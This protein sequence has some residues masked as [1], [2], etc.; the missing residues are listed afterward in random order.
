MLHTIIGCQYETNVTIKCQC[1]ANIGIISLDKISPLGLLILPRVICSLTRERQRQYRQWETNVGPIYSSGV[2]FLEG[3]RGQGM[4]IGAP[5]IKN[6]KNRRAQRA[7]ALQRWV[8]GQMK[9]LSG[10]Q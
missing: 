8:Q 6:L 4:A 5:L 9:G 10:V 2:T 3:A 1:Q 7:R